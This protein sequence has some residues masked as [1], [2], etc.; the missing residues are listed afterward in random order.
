MKKTIEM[1]KTL[2]RIIIN[3]LGMVL[4]VGCSSPDE[5]ANK[6]FVEAS[7]LV[8]LVQ[9][10]ERT[11]YF[12]AFK[13][14]KDALEKLERITAK[15]PSSQLAVKI[16]Q[17][18]AK[19]GPYT[20]TDFKDSIVYQGKERVAAE[21]SPFACALLVAETIEH[22]YPKGEA[23]ASI[24]SIVINYTEPE[25]EDKASETLSQALQIAEAEKIAVV[26]DMMLSGVAGNYAVAGQRNHAVQLAK[27]IRDAGEKASALAEIGSAYVKDKE[28]IDMIAQ[29]RFCTK[30]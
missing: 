22:D 13:L 30:L 25:Q 11:S 17:G 27:T 3:C 7:Q 12:D 5:K 20:I 6:L 28:R 21:E 26:K 15:Y 2:F 24:V 18:E 1:K 19:I 4:F 10:V 8:K 14:Y 23:L 16:V 29:E 9:E